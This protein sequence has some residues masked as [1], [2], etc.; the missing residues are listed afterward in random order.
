MPLLPSKTVES[1]HPCL[2]SVEMRDK[3]VIAVSGPPGSG[4]TTYA[5]RLAEELGLGYHSAGL[6][7][8]ELAREKG[9]SLEELSRLAEADPTIDLEIDRR[10][11]HLGLQGNMVID[12]H[13]VAWILK[14]VADVRIY[15]TAPLHVRVRRIAL[16][17]RRGEKE[18]LRETL[19]REWSNKK[20]FKEYYGIDVTDTSLFDLVIDTSRLSV[21]EAYNIIHAFVSTV[22]SRSNETSKNP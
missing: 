11:L 22:L 19:V 10:T 3:P 21:D 8:R 14:D 9:M 16:R 2:L 7:F 20:R 18:V 13:L 15:I 1:K 5:R 17:E 4:K 12:G 6:I